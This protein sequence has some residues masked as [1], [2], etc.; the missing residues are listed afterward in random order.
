VHVF[1]IR[2][3]TPAVVNDRGWRHAGAELVVG[4]DR[5][6]FQVDL[7][8]WGIGDYQRQWREGIARLA[9]GDSSSALMSAYRGPG[10]TEH[11]LW[12]LWREG[13]HVYVQGQ[14]VLPVEADLLFDPSSPY[15]HVGERIAAS[16]YGLPIPEWRVDLK[17]LLLADLGIRWS[18]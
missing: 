9:K 13:N 6:F 12:A 11:T 8:H 17:S 10:D 4:S 5:R 2:V 7:S 1:R 18:N 14:A 15:P 16:A 3:F